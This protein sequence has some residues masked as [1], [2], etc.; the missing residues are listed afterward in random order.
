MIKLLFKLPNNLL[1][2]YLDNNIE[3]LKEKDFFLLV[4]H[5]ILIP[6]ELYH[7]NKEF[8]NSTNIL[9]WVIF[10]DPNSVFEFNPQL[11]TDDI[12]DDIAISNIVLTE[13]LIKQ[14]PVFF[15][16]QRMVERIVK[17]F[18]HLIR[19]LKQEQVTD[20][21]I[22]KL[23]LNKYVL[24]EEDINKF[25]FLLNNLTLSTLALE[26]NPKLVFKLPKLSKNHIHF[27]KAHKLIPTY[28][29]YLK[30]PILSEDPFLLKNSFKKDVSCIVFMN[31]DCLDFYI[32]Q[33]ARKR[34]F[35]ADEKDLLFNPLLCKYQPIM[36]PAIMNNPSLIVYT[37]FTCSLSEE[38]VNYALDNFLITIDI[39]EE[40]PDLCGNYDIINKLPQF[41]NYSL[42]KT[43]QEKIDDIV[44]YLEENNIE[45]LRNLPFLRKKYWSKSDIDDKIN[46]IKLLYEKIKTDKIEDQKNHFYFLD[47]LIDG[48]CSIRYHE[49]KDKFEFGDIASL[50]NYIVTEFIR[51]QDKYSLMLLVD[52]LS[53]FTEQEIS[54]DKLKDQIFTLYNLFLSRHTSLLL[55][56][57]NVLCNKILNAHRNSFFKYERKKIVN[58]LVNRLELTDKK[59]SVLNN[60]YKFPQIARLIKNRCYDELNTSEMQLKNFIKEARMRFYNNRRLKKNGIILSEELLDHL[61]QTFF[62]NGTLKVSDL[63]STIPLKSAKYICNNYEKI[64]LHFVDSISLGT[65][66]INRQGLNLDYNTFVI[67]S[68]NQNFIILAKLILTLEEDKLKSIIN[69][70]K[71]ISELKPIIPYVDLFDEYSLNTFINVLDTYPRVKQRILTISQDYSLT[72]KFR[73][74][75]TLANAYSS[76][77]DIHLF[78]LTDKVVKVLGEEKSQDY[79]DF[80]LEMLKKKVCYIPPIY[81]TDDNLIFYSGNYS[82]QD[83]LLIG[84]RYKDSCIDLDNL[85]GMQTFKECLIGKCG[86]VILVKTK[87]KKEFAGRILLIRRGNIV[88]LIVKYGDNFSLDVY[89]KIAN[90]IIRQSELVDDNIEYVVINHKAISDIEN[91]V[92]LN[93]ASFVLRFPHADLSSKVV[94]LASHSSQ[95]NLDEI[96]K[97]LDFNINPK[98]KYSK[99]RKKISY[100]PTEAEI[101]RIRALN[102]L[103]QDDIILREDM[104]RNFEPFYSEAYDKSICGE[105]WYIARK[106]TGE[107][108]EVILPHADIITKKE[109]YEMRNMILTND[110]KF[111]LPRK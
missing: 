105:E 45:G 59:Q 64:K 52:K 106:I 24:K 69:N 36:E 110:L 87:D 75:V 31:E 1:L 6:R 5:N 47:K 109:F 65:H 7:R 55:S 108:E 78:A 83:K 111:N 72:S 73:D 84:K 57:T 30:Y 42:Y 49:Q 18:P 82:D 103:L 63:P 2:K 104:A 16:N 51:I 29:D 32:T 60:R 76:I 88:Q 4:T 39:L 37:E 70:G 44:K 96:N 25:P 56:D 17:E 86:D 40:H 41:Q 28:D 27:I 74:L 93:N 81:I 26:Q 61:D 34:G 23:V 33:E 68:K 89:K 94:L 10:N 13:D 107:L 53:E 54:R 66:K 9:E 38:C 48:V 98:Y 12:L 8:I 92:V 71:I 50:H 19:N 90:E 85:A 20:K 95:L 102:I 97:N 100:N 79:L 91:Q 43:E 77:D 21:V 35:I 62:E 15:T 22:D 58:K 80:Y 101:S 46:L 99:F 14:Y 11:F 3:E 67:V